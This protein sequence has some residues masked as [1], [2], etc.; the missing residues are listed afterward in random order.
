MT[1]SVDAAWVW[2]T[3]F[4][5]LERSRRVPHEAGM[6]AI[7]RYMSMELGVCHDRQQIHATHTEE[8]LSVSLS[9]F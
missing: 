5:C 1:V 6:R 8:D 3:R 9:G 4:L 2:T 7:G